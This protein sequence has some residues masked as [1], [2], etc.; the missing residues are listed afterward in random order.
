MTEIV[1]EEQHTYWNEEGGPKWVEYQDKLDAQLQWVADKLLEI[2]HVQHGEHVLDIG[3]GC[4]ATTLA[5][6]KAVGYEA[7]VT[8]VDLSEP[9]LD[10]ARQRAHEDGFAQAEF[11]Q[12]DAQVHHFGTHTY[13]LA[14]SRFGVMFF[15]DPVAAFANIR[16]A[17][18]PG[19]RLVFLCWRSPKENPWATIPMQAAAQH[20]EP[21]EAPAPGAPGPFAFADPDHVKTI[22]TDAGYTDIRIDPYTQE[23]ILGGGG[24][25]EDSIDFI[26]SI[27]PMSRV[28]KDATPEQLK[29]IRASVT[30]ALGP[31]HTPDG[32]KMDSATWVVTAGN[33]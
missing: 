6:A 21:P 23:A 24:S 18:K 25:L 5:F 22:L 14:V 2:A 20:I 28:V 30:E 33:G 3:C 26:F 10:H 32:I 1:N 29:K 7:R 19:G 11:H 16:S 4:G 15:E 12:C 17:L 9:M 31:Y 27:G 13:D 8:G